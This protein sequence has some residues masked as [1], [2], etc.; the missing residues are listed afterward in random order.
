MRHK[1][2]WLFASFHQKLLKGMEGKLTRAILLNSIMSA[3]DQMDT[4][5]IGTVLSTSI[6]L[7]LF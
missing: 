7:S 4:L 6:K 1:V 5:F 2:L 3:E